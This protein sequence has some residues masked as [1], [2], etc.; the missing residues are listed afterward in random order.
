[1]ADTDED[2]T[3]A[4]LQETLAKAQKPTSGAKAELEE[5]VEDLSRE[6]RPDVFVARVIRR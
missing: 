5:R 6:H 4:E 3:K 1:M 2:K